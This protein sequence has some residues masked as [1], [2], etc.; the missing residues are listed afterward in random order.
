LKPGWTKS[1]LCVSAIVA[2]LATT[3]FALPQDPKSIKRKNELS[4][5][6]IRPGKDTLSAAKKSLAYR[7]LRQEEKSPHEWFYWDNCGGL[8]IRIETD[9]KELIQTVHI[10]DF[11]KVGDCTGH[12]NMSFWATG[13]GLRLHDKLERAI[14]IYG[15]P[16]SRGPSVKNGQEL[17]LLYY[18]FDWAGSDVPQV[19]EISCDKASGRVVEIMLAFPSL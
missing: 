2:L 9:D 7:V 12:A 10:G 6:G 1:W 18:A 3:A 19:M 4:L 8:Q 11:M 17:E 14:E 16:N 15:E 13:R 5:S